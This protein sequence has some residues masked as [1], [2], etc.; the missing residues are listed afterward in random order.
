MTFTLFPG[1][2][3]ALA[4]DSLAGL[5]VGDAL[6]AQFFIPG[7]SL[8]VPPDPP[9]PWTDDT[10][11]ACCIVA[12]LGAGDFDRDRFAALLGRHFDP[13]RG[14]GPGAVVMLR[15]LRGGTPWPIAAAAA[16]EGQGSAG[17]G[18]AMRAAPL[19][20]WH[21]DSPAHAAEQGARAAEV[22]HAHPE[23]IAGGV[24]VTVAAAVAAAARLDGQP[25]DLLGAV[26]AHTPQ[27]VVR[28]GLRAATRIA[29]AEE[30]AHELGNG[31]RST[32]VDSVPFALWVATHHLGDYPAAVQACIAAGGDMDTTAAMAGGIVAA[33][34]GIDG[35][36]KEWLAAREPLPEWVTD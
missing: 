7:Q 35:I 4:A 13:Y 26:L 11:E 31:T 30:A 24:A 25:V 22:T 28:D 23:G 36:P 32:A 10:E 3:A 8:D 9:W 27:S 33:Y 12:T 1:T 34:T 5:S 16:F 6:G 15:Q 29:T 2:R 14:Y 17:N 19:G 20:A 21:A 18:A